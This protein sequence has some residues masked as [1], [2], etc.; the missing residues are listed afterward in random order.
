MFDFKVYAEEPSIIHEF[1]S[2]DY[3]ADIILDDFGEICTTWLRREHP[4]CTFVYEPECCT[5]FL[6]GGHGLSEEQIRLI[7]SKAM[8]FVCGLMYGAE[9]ARGLKR[10]VPL[11]EK[12]RKDR[13]DRLNEYIRLGEDSYDQ[14]YEPRVHTNPAGHY[15]DAKDFFIEAIGLARELGL[16]DQAQTLSER[17]AHIKAVYRSQF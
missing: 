2:T 10:D 4:Q 15:S 16:I 12:E 7:Q 13:L 1:S 6:D 8:A 9:I 11:T 17:L 5:L 3:P 14:L